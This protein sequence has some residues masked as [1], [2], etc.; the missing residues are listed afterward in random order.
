MKKTIADLYIGG[1]IRLDKRELI[2][3]NGILTPDMT[4]LGYA[5]CVYGK[6][7]IYN[8]ETRS[9][10]Q[11]ATRDANYNLDLKNLKVGMIYIKDLVPIHEVYSKYPIRKHLKKSILREIRYALEESGR[12]FATEE[13]VKSLIRT[14]K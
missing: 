7:S 14:I 6:Q 3:V 11:E 1:M 13:H 4:W 12:V 10:Y 5:L 9:F 8:F 2:I